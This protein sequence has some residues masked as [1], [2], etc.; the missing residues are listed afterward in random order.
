M[1]RSCAIAPAPPSPPLRSAGGK[2]TNSIPLVNERRTQTKWFRNKNSV[3]KKGAVLGFSVAA[4]HSA[5]ELSGT[6]AS[7]HCSDTG[8]R[9]FGF[10]FFLSFSQSHYQLGHHKFKDMIA[11]EC[12]Y[13]KLMSE[14]S[15][16][17]KII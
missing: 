1:Y 10:L 14:C 5:T 6:L 4:P 17:R 7:S 11:P 12:K 8:M 13:R 3:S 15:R 9:S 16:E 2:E